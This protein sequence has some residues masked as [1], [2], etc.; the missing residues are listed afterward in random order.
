MKVGV[1]ILTDLAGR[2]H[3]DVGKK[4]RML[5]V[6]CEFKIFVRLDAGQNFQKEGVAG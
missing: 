2:E 4:C 5:C 1:R 3:C 6:L